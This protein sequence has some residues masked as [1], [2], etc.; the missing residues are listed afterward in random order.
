VPCCWP[1]NH[2]SGYS[3]LY[4]KAMDL[5]GQ[6]RWPCHQ[7]KFRPSDPHRS[8]TRDTG[9]DRWVPRL[10]KK[11]QL[12]GW[13]AGIIFGPAWLIEKYRARSCMLSQCRPGPSYIPFLWSVAPPYQ[14]CGTDASCEPAA[15]LQQRQ[16]CRSAYSDSLGLLTRPSA[17]QLSYFY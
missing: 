12:A 7:K 3:I 10:G 15:R 1:M 16:S 11:Y 5:A 14:R 17:N 4:I 6:R 2:C 13:K 9:T 8:S